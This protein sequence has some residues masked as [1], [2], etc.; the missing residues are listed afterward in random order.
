MHSETLT[1][2][3]ALHFLY[4]FTQG[5]MD[6]WCIAMVTERGQSCMTLD[7]LNKGTLIQL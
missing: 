3:K 6:Y 1:H 4:S 2:I 7:T 5:K